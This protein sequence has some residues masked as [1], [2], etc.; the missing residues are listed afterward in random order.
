MSRERAEFSEKIDN[1]W[2][3]K[4]PKGFFQ[5]GPKYMQSHPEEE[6]TMQ[7]TGGRIYLRRMKKRVNGERPK[8]RIN[9]QIISWA[10]LKMKNP[11]IKK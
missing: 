7:I 6:F 5:K 10:P 4:F 2:I 9:G 3:A 1:S 11:E 8:S